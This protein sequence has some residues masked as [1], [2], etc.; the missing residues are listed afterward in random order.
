MHWQFNNDKKYLLEQA[1]D[2][3]NVMQIQDFS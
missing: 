2:F 3:Q 1:M